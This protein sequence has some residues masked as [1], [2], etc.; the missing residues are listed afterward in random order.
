MTKEALPHMHCLHNPTHLH[1]HMHLPRN[2]YLHLLRPNKLITLLDC[3]TCVCMWFAE[4]TEDRHEGLVPPN[5]V[6]ISWK[7]DSASKILFK[8]HLKQHYVEIVWS[9]VSESNTTVVN[10]NSG[11]VTVCHNVIKVL[12]KNKTHD[13]ITVICFKTCMLTWTCVTLF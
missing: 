9:G 13:V 8:L 4:N 5:T 7:C 1:A 12:N 2:W 6:I 10:T 3:W 11:C